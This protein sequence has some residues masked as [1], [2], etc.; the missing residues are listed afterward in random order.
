MSH[1]VDT[2]FSEP[3]LQSFYDPM[4][5]KSANP[6]SSS[7]AAAAA[8]TSSSL[9]AVISCGSMFQFLKYLVQKMTRTAQNAQGQSTDILTQLSNLLPT[10]TFM[11]F[12]ALATLTTN[13]GDCG[14][15]DKVV[16]AVMLVILGAICAFSCFTDS[17]KAENGVVY[18]GVVTTTGLWNPCFVGSGLANVSGAFYIGDNAKYN[19]RVFDFVNAMLSV[20]AFAALTLLT[21]PVTTC[22]YPHIPDSVVKS[23]P[24]LVGAL[25]AIVTPYAPPARNGFGHAIPESATPTNSC[26]TT[27]SL[28]HNSS[29]ASTI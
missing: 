28:L 27:T 1:S 5:S 13:N 29:T 8:T 22:Y 26:S 14:H 18:Y 24:I 11:L 25:I 2:S 12:Q 9:N 23:L 17:Y 6:L 15:T 7:S 10:G 16:T 4:V 21:A 19:L 3:Q 20:M